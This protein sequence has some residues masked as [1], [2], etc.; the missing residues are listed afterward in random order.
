[1]DG[2]NLDGGNAVAKFKVIH[3]NHAPKWIADPLKLPDAF[4]GKDYI[5]SLFNS[6]GDED[7]D[8]QTFK[9]DAGPAWLTM[10]DDTGEI[11][12]KPDKSNLNLKTWIV[13]VS[14]PDGLSDT[15]TLQINVIKSNEPPFFL[16]KPTIMEDAPE[17]SP[18]SADLTSRVLDP[19]G[20][21]IT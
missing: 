18:Y 3:V 13:T 11:K 1:V 16:K 4:T 10:N 5:N 21:P 19:D 9:I 6:A 8:K 15:A 20:D 7:G 2:Q 12:G 14:D 17:R